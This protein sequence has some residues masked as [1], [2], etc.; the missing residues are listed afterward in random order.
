MQE[1]T[2]ENQKENCEC[3]WSGRNLKGKYIPEHKL[4]PIPA[5][6]WKFVFSIHDG[7]RI[8]T[9]LRG[10]VCAICHNYAESES[11]ELPLWMD[12]L[13]SVELQDTRV[14]HLRRDGEEGKGVM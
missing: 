2:T 8:P 11:I 10:V 5:W 3:I 6:E 4:D 12:E 9:L 14:V 7:K 1:T 13:P